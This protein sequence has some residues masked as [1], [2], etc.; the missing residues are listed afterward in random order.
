L[1]SAARSFPCVGSV[2]ICVSIEISEVAM[3]APLFLRPANAEQ[4]ANIVR[5]LP[6]A[7]G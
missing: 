5:G 1:V 6:L 3:V 4:G 2:A 7:A